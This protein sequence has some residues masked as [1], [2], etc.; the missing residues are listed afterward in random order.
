MTAVAIENFVVTGAAGGGGTFNY[1][2]SMRLRESGGGAATI[3]GVTLTMT[4]TS[5]I[6]VS[7]EVAP[8]QAFPTTTLAANSTLESNTLSINGAPVQASQLAVRITYTSASGASQSVQATTNVV[9]S[10][11][12][13]KR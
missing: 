5:G 8:S 13:G 2:A 10:S 9:Y 4:T 12:V 11:V 6:T 3:T 1:R 7:Q